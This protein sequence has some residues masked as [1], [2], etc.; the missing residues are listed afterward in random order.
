MESPG[1]YTQRAIVARILERIDAGWREQYER[2]LDLSGREPSPI[3]A[4]SLFFVVTFFVL[5]W[6]LANWR[7]M[8]QITPAIAITAIVSIASVRFH[9]FDRAY[10]QYLEQR[11]DV[12]A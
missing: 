9:S 3:N 2:F 5:C 12:T 8:G 1:N 10:R 6:G 7:G 4:R 11:A